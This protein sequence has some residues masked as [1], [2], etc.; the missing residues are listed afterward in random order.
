MLQYLVGRTV[1]VDSI[2][3]GQLPI[4]AGAA[5]SW[6][7]SGANGSRLRLRFR[8]NRPAI[9]LRPSSCTKDTF[10]CPGRYPNDS[11]TDAP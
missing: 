4:R 11:K 9:M 7:A 10:P 2:R 8:G 1:P 6:H 3:R 5:L